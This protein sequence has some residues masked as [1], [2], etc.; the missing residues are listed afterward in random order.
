LNAF[1]LRD[2]GS[3][4]N[5]QTLTA[6]EACRPHQYWLGRGFSEVEQLEI[7]KSM[8]YEEV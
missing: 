8:P 1:F 4:P 3:A 5:V 7:M 2:D 6:A